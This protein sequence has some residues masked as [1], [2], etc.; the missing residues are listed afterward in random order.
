VTA[1]IATGPERSHVVPGTLQEP[2]QIVTMIVAGRR[3]FVLCA[4]A[5]IRRCRKAGGF[6]NA[7]GTI[8]N[9]CLPSN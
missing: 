7:A 2:R 4:T 8:R 6:C 3:E 1:E 9:R 5:L